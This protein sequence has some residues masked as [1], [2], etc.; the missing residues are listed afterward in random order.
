[1]LQK[2]NV[3]VNT[4]KLDKPEDAACVIAC[5]VVYIISNILE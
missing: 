1:V 3:F 5:G 2:G 4:I